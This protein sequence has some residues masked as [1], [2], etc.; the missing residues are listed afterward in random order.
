MAQ[1]TRYWSCTPF[2][3]WLRGTKKLSMG[4]SEQW[5]EWTTAAQMKHNFRYWLAE[6][7][8]GHLQDFVTWPIRKVYDA[9]YYIN[10]RWVTRTH[11]LTAHPRDI[12]PGSWSDVGNR[13]LPC[14]FN[15]LVDFV[16]IE[17]A[18]SHIAWGSEEDRAKY[19]A[20]FWATGWFR[21]RTW[22]CPQ[23][24]LEH[25]NWAMSLTCGEDWGVDKD[26]PDFGKPTGQALRAKE[27]KELYL[28]WTVAYRNRPD[29]YEASGWTAACEAQREANGGK[30]NWS[31][32][33]KNPTLKK[34]SDKA[35]KLLQKI[36]TA[37]EKEDEA[38]MI[39][40]IKVRH[41]L[42]T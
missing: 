29:P 20:P 32:R 38:M 16:E 6:E 41:G 17:T 11:A 9:K 24:G 27:I 22:R 3:D 19:K 26:S 13:F 28:W 4:T 8:L 1:H 42:W 21:W 35:H 40:L 12:K 39:R 36:E 18:W 10:N 31:S 23:A 34:A 15:E 33:E 37:Y 7:A 25:L 14:L 2:A 5:D 30:F